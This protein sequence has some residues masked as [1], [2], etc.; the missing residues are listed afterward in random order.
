MNDTTTT[1]KAPSNGTNFDPP[2]LNVSKQL[3]QK[4]LSAS[5]NDVINSNQTQNKDIVA[6]ALANISSILNSKKPSES[7]LNDTKSIYKAPSN[8]SNLSPTP[9]DVSNEFLQN[10]MNTSSN[11]V[12]N[13]NQSL[14]KGS[15]AETL[16]NI[17][18]IL[19]SEKQS[20]SNN[21]RQLS[22]Q[23]TSI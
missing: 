4:N 2:P 7:N 1:N 13:V 14:N 12:T 6:D 9:L 3:L 11:D 20:E 23:K 5:S 10:N 17:T 22:M 8:G 16:A 15:V 18:N 19:N 21:K